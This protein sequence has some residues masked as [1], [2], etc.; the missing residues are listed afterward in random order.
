MVGASQVAVVEENAWI[1]L[2]RPERKM[3]V[4]GRENGRRKN[5]GAI[6]ERI[7]RVETEVPSVECF[8]ICLISWFLCFFVW[9]AGEVSMSDV[10]VALCA[11]KTRRIRR[12]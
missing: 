9:R 11:G 1:V 12:V 5:L 6:V 2:D 3:S 8:A 10:L 4:D 7:L